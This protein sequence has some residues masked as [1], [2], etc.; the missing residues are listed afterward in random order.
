MAR[1][2]I[3]RQ[4]R[5]PPVL[6]RDPGLEPRGRHALYVRDPLR[7]GVFVLD[8]Y[9]AI[10]A[11]TMGR[12]DHMARL[13]RRDRQPAALQNDAV[14]AN[15]EVMARVDPAFLGAEAAG[16]HME[17]LNIAGVPLGLRDRLRT[18]E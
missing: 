15:E 13:D 5:G 3:G 14:A 2:R 11:R 7:T 8:P 6:P 4:Y 10:L 1:V 12:V 16:R 9:L 17:R 18:R